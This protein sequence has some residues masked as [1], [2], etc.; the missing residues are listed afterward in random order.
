MTKATNKRKKFLIQPAF[1]ISV[2]KHMTL[3]TVFVIMTF[4]SAN[5]YHFW[6]LRERG[7]KLG[8]APDHIFFEFLRSQQRTMDLIF[9]VTSIVV[10]AIIVGFGV[11]LSHRVAGP[12][13]RLKTYL[14]EDHSKTKYPLKFRKNDYFTDVADALNKRLG[15][16]DPGST[17]EGS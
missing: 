3:L 2:I 4:Y 15:L 16:A 17:K 7:L 8:L 6:S 10:L 11:F 13:H 12:L 1:Q 14:G 9:I 5:L